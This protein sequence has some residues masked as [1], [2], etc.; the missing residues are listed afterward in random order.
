MTNSRPVKQEVGNVVAKPEQMRSKSVS[1]KLVTLPWLLDL[2][3]QAKLLK[4]FI[5]ADPYIASDSTLK[6]K[7]FCSEVYT[8]KGY[9]F[10]HF[11]VLSQMNLIDINMDYLQSLR[12]KKKKRKF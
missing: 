5:R 10:L 4:H 11:S 3:A 7:M 1:R 9:I 2:G 8:G 12:K 6:L